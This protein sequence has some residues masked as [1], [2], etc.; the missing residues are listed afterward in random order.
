MD[1]ETL[2][3]KV[4]AA[5]TATFGALRSE[6]ADEHFYAFALY[7]DGDAE[8]IMPSA[9]SVER[10]QAVLQKNKSDHPLDLA[11]YKWA[12]AEWAYEAWE[13][14]PKLFDGVYRDLA[15]LRDAL[16]TVEVEVECW[17]GKVITSRELADELSYKRAVHQC[18]IDALNRMDEDG[19]FGPGR[20]DVVLFVSSSDDDEACDLENESAKQLNPE[21]VYLPFLK[22]YDV[23]E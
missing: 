11:S 18:M 12:T 15:E 21:D 13:P 16:P 2:T 6:K 3:S 23:A 1:W 10:L 8:T 4:V 7:T 9:N 19:C 5:A 20:E 14:D 22:R 17:P